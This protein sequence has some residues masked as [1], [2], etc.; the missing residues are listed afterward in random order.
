MQ[1]LI[2]ALLAEFAIQFVLSKGSGAAAEGP[3][4][5]RGIGGVVSPV[6]QIQITIVH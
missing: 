1:R 3:G 2:C 6:S 4:G 5:E